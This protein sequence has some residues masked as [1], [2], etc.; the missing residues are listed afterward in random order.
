MFLFI[1]G[2]FSLMCGVC[3]LDSANSEGWIIACLAGV[4]L[5]MVGSAQMSDKGD[6][7]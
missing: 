1:I 6:K 7:K 3:G 4:I 2:I 5:L